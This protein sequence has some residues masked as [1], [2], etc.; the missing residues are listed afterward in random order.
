LFSSAHADYGKE[1]SA[2]KKNDYA[3]IA[4]RKVKV[5]PAEIAKETATGEP[6]PLAFSQQLPK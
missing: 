3:I 5:H 4:R 6:D 2:E 1:Q